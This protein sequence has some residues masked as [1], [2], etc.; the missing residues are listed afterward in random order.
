MYGASLSTLIF[1][2]H[3]ASLQTLQTC[4]H[5][6]LVVARARRSES[7]KKERADTDVPQ[8]T[9]D[10]L[11][12]VAWTMADPLGWLVGALGQEGNC[13]PIGRALNFFPDQVLLKGIPIR[14]LRS[15]CLGPGLHQPSFVEEALGRARGG[16]RGVRSKREASARR[17]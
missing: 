8:T 11:V 5:F 1:V 3:E 15:R 2:D 6:S 7:S 4:V 12:D 17:A 13:W 10:L 16:E 9:V 14:F